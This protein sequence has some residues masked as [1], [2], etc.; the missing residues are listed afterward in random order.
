[1]VRPDML[2]SSSVCRSIKRIY[3][4]ASQLCNLLS[5]TVGTMPGPGSQRH[6]PDR[7]RIAPIYFEGSKRFFVARSLMASTIAAF[8]SVPRE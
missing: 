3:Y 4:R 2:E 7:P 1:V 6:A 5:P 8:M